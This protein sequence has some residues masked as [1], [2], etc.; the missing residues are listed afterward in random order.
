MA[1]VCVGPR[2]NC[3]RFGDV[4]VCPVEEGTIVGAETGGVV[5]PAGEE[6]DTIA[7]STDSRNAGLGSLRRVG[8][9]LRRPSDGVTD[10]TRNGVGRLVGISE[11]SNGSAAST[12]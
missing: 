6:V 12:S 8:P 3:G 7:G 10:D 1:A 2:V 9:S 11:G 5:S 4:I